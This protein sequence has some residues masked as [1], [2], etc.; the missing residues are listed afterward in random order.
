MNFGMGALP[1]LVLFYVAVWAFGIYLV[2]RV[3][4]AFERVADAHERIAT[5][6]TKR[7]TNPSGDFH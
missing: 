6:L 1:V 2:V 3:I 5:A 7:G 4:R